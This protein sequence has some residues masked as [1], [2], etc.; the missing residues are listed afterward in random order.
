MHDR[1]IFRA[2][3]VVAAASALTLLAPAAQAQR[4]GLAASPSVQVALPDSFPSPDARALVV[5]FA[6]GRDL[7]ILNREHATPHAL[8]A[9]VALLKEL[10]RTNPRVA[11]TQVVTMQG[12]TPLGAARGRTGAAFRATIEAL[13]RQPPARIGNLGRGRW[14]ELGDPGSA[15]GRA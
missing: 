6:T 15:R 8:A 5:R 10:R 2:T 4:D 11:N 14:I 7:I 3:T 12:F 9:A 1:T 13:N